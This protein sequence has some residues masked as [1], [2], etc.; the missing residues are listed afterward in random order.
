MRFL[1]SAFALVSAVFGQTYTGLQFTHYTDR[2]CMQGANATTYALGK[3]MAERDGRS[4]EYHCSSDGKTAFD[5]EYADAACARQAG[6]P[7]RIVVGQC[8]ALGTSGSFNA[9][10]VSAEEPEFEPEEA[11]TTLTFSHYTDRGCKE[12]LNATIV[13]LDKCLPEQNNMRSRKLSCAVDGKSATD[14]EYADNMCGRAA[15][16]PHTIRT[17]ECLNLLDRGSFTAKCS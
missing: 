9:R 14:T 15:G 7:R 3:C 1:F 5:Q 6:D 2:A 11:Y 12:G 17:D 8:V 4:R 13:A 16:A 10:C